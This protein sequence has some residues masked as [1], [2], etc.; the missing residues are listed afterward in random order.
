MTT[1]QGRPPF[2]QFT[3]QDLDLQ[4]LIER[5]LPGLAKI[6][7][8]D[9][10]KS[11]TISL[12]E[13]VRGFGTINRTKRPKLRSWWQP[14]NGALYYIATYDAGYEAYKKGDFGN[15]DSDIIKRFYLFQAPNAEVR[16]MQTTTFT[17]RKFV[18]LD[19]LR[20][21]PRPD[22]IIVKT[23]RQRAGLDKAT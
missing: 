11:N 1:E 3:D 5:A 22:G 10:G 16:F 18:Q 9:L 4:A 17:R 6:P 20:E 2:D 14:R 12:A 13:E 8:I 19:F 23:L 15:V 21:D 7:N